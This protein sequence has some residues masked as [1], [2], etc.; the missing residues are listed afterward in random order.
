[1]V[2]KARACGGYH[3]LVVAELTAF[4]TDGPP[5]RYDLIVSAD[6]LVYFGSLEHVLRGAAASLR[7]GGHLVFTV[8][9]AEGDDGDGFV[10]NPHGRYAHGEPYVR[11]VLEHVAGLEVLAVGRE[12]LRME[13]GQPVRGLIVTARK[14]GPSSVSPEQ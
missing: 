10:L 8:E 5:Q 11:H 7:P 13:M 14:P 1:M 4:L 3:D 2:D 9:A 12:P 6:T